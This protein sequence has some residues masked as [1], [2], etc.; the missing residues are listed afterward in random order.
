MIKKSLY[1]VLTKSS[2]S[3]HVECFGEHDGAGVVTVRFHSIKVAMLAYE[4]LMH[5]SIFK[6]NVKFDTD[7][8]SAV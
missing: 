4:F 1:N 8:C 3:T 5:Q 6:G 2:F 7:P